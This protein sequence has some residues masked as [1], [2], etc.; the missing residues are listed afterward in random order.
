M[1][2]GEALYIRRFEV[3]VGWKTVELRVLCD[4]KSSKIS[5][6]HSFLGYGKISSGLLN[7]DSTEGDWLQKDGCVKH[8]YLVMEDLCVTTNLVG[9]KAV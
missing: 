3:L 2:W 1:S 7:Q 9:A 4:W 6:K 8:D 5:S